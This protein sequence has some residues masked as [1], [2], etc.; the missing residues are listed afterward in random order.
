MN[1][2]YAVLGYLTFNLNA[3][4]DLISSNSDLCVTSL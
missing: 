4:V 2:R 3:D 1:N